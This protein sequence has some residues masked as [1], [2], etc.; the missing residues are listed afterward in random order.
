LAQTPFSPPPP[1][2]PRPIDE[3]EDDEGYR[4]THSSED[5]EDHVIANK[6][7][8]IGLTDNIIDVGDGSEQSVNKPSVWEVHFKTMTPVFIKEEVMRVFHVNI[9][10]WTTWNA[11]FK[12]LQQIYGD[13]R[14]SYNMVPVL[15]NM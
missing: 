2:P 3:I 11:R 13:Y 12:S 7:D 4:S 8:F 5:E 6:V 14:E 10:Y 1:P 9:S 15:C